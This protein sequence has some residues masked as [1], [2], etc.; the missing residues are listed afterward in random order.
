MLPSNAIF[1]TSLEPQNDPKKG[2]LRNCGSCTFNGNGAYCTR[3]DYP[4]FRDSLRCGGY[5]FLAKPFN[6]ETA[7]VKPS[8]L[9]PLPDNYQAVVTFCNNHNLHLPHPHPWRIV[10]KP[11]TGC[12]QGLEKR[13]NFRGTAMLSNGIEV[14]ILREDGNV[15]LGHA[16]SFVADK[17]YINT[18]DRLHIK[19]TKK[20]K[21]AH[22]VNLECWI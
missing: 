21:V 15:V 11:F 2:L 14:A 12:I 8:K 7:I 16:D 6:V 22:E 20:E 5:S 4:V 17:K 1:H 10:L 13:G 9:L 18:K 19:A 3:H